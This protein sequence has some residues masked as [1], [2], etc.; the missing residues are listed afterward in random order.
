MEAPPRTE[1]PTWPFTDVTEGDDWFYDAVAYVYEN[2][3]MAGTSETT[4]EPGML[5]R[6]TVSTI[7]AEPITKEA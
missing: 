5:L 1:E 3:I 6:I 7:K 2:G 4:F